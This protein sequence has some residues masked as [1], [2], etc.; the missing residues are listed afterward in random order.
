M[1]YEEGSMT[2]IACDCD[3]LVLEGNA[4]VKESCNPLA[5]LSHH[6]GLSITTRQL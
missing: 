4:S 6:S 5:T 1:R 2:V 3:M